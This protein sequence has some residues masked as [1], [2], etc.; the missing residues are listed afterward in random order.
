[1]TISGGPRSRIGGSL[2]TI[3]TGRDLSS[4]PVDD[5]RLSVLL[6]LVTTIAADRAP[7][8]APV[9]YVVVRSESGRG[10]LID[11]VRRGTREMAALRA[12]CPPGG[13]PGLHADWCAAL[14]EAEVAWLRHAPVWACPYV[15]ASPGS[16]PRDRRG[17]LALAV[18]TLGLLA[19]AMGMRA[20]PTVRHL[21]HEPSVRALLALPAHL[22]TGA[23]V[24]LGFPSRG[25]GGLR[26]RV[27]G[28]QRR[29][30]TAFTERFGG[31]A[32]AV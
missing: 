12:P 20:I 8:L 11:L 28:P 23:A 9:G 2:L 21:R 29:T 32:L 4:R 18:E 27:S 7:A 5:L 13:D 19:G 15:A 26:P 30:C 1:M 24:A 25:T 31:A 6:Q 3:R 10:A 22:E 17:A 16:G 14:A